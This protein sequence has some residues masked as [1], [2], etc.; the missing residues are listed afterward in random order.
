MLAPSAPALRSVRLS[1]EV[2]LAQLPGWK[3]AAFVLREMLAPARV[4]VEVDLY[5]HW[6][7]LRWA[8]IRMHAERY[9]HVY[10][11]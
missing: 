3:V 11:G 10:F 9:L 4:E 8:R 2:R 6:E 7:D 1:D 5:L